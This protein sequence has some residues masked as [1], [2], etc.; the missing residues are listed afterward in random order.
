MI[1]QNLQSHACATVHR[2]ATLRLP[3]EPLLAVLRN[4]AVSEDGALHA[5]KY[6]QTTCDEFHRSRPAFRWRHLTAL[7]RVTSS[8]YGSPAPGQAEARELLLKA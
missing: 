6:Y 1:R 8:A 7:A 4:Y 3:E 2:W 5:E